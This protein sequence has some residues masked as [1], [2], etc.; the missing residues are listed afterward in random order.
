[1]PIG[2]R[3]RLGGRG[4]TYGHSERTL[5][6]LRQ[7]EQEEREAFERSRRGELGNLEDILSERFLPA[8]EDAQQASAER[9]QQILDTLAEPI[10][11]GAA[12]GSV[13]TE[14]EAIISDLFGPGGAVESARS[15][16]LGALVDRGLSPAGGSA[17]RAYQNILG[18][19]RGEVTNRVAQRATQLAPLAV[20]Q[21]GQDLSSLANLY[22]AEQSRE[23]DVLNS[24]FGGRASEAQLGL[25]RQTQD[26]NRRIVEAQL[27]QLEDQRSGGGFGGF[28]GDLLGGVGSAVTGGLA[29]GIASGIFG[30]TEDFVSELF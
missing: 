7:R 14:A 23:L 17:Q 28:L 30:G 29:G 24:L 15:E 21:R 25:S 18:E 26:L 6:G 20:Q 10:D 9:E 2:P 16:S 3:G 22:G 4:T 11:Y 8:Y 27:R 5:R 13:S 12:L 1:M 19:A